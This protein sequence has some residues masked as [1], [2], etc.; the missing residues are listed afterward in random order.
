MTL[1]VSEVESACITR[2]TSETGAREKRESERDRTHDENQAE[3][4][5][6][7]ETDNTTHPKTI[8]YNVDT[9]PIPSRRM[10]PLFPPLVHLMPDAIV[11]TRIRRGRHEMGWDGGGVSSTSHEPRDRWMDGRGGGTD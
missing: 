10:S 3:G 2:P 1:K 7:D 4:R 5:R 8:T 11:V 6:G 9:H